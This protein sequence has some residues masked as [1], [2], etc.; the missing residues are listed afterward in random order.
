MTF[1]KQGGGGRRGAPREA[2]PLLA[3]YTTVTNSHEVVLVDVSSSGARLRGPILPEAGDDLFVSVENIKVFGTVV[4]LEGH[5]FAVAFDRPLPS[6][7]LALLR[8]KVRQGAGFSPEERAAI[9]G[10]V[11]GVD[12]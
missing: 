12:R 7:D 1:G 8:S 3:V 2:T 5:E 9:D 11:L 10:W 4:R 6:E